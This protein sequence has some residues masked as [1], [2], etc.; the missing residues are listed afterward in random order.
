MWLLL[1]TT[2]TSL[3]AEPWPQRACDMPGA[4]LATSSAQSA[5]QCEATCGE[6]ADCGGYTFV[7]GLNRCTL[8]QP[9]AKS[10]EVHM[11]AAR[12]L[13]SDGQRSTTE[14]KADHDHGGRDLEPSPRD[15]PT[16]TAC[17]AACVSTEA[18]VGFVYIQGYRSC[19]LKATDGAISPKHFV[20]A[21]RPLA[22]VP[23]PLA[24]AVPSP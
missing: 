7:S 18:C 12:L 17:A 4:N 13:V 10:F 14:P 19:W 16:T 6:R 21:S 8:E 3:A 11:H 2:V 24:P 22:E 1:L 9:G 20:C 23:A 15:L 5:E